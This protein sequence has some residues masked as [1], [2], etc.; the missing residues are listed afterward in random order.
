M[1]IMGIGKVGMRGE[2]ALAETSTEDKR[3]ARTRAALTQAF[4]DLVAEQDYA[5][6]SI[7]DVIAR[8]EVG[9]STFYQHYANKDEILTA[10]MEGGFA[11]L[12]D[13]VNDGPHTRY[14]E[15]WLEIFWTNRRA[16]R[17][18]LS[19]PTRKFISRE[20]AGRIENRLRGDARLAPMRAD[21]SVTLIAAT[22]G[23]AQLGLIQAWIEGRAAAKTSAMAQALREATRRLAGGD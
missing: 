4:M 12:T 9:R 1:F 11:A 15:D 18:L 20:L 21:I 5:S 16:G 19:G 22:V 17:V 10:V 7:S 2:G 8:A 23:E 13:L 6:I 14:L 3:V